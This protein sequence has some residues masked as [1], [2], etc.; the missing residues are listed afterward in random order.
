MSS[1]SPSEDPPPAAR[2]DGYADWY[3]EWASTGLTAAAEALGE[4][5]P[6]GN[7]LAV[8]VGCGTGRT[9]ELLR[10]HGYRP[11]GVDVSADQ[12][13]VARARLPVLRGEGGAL[14]LPDGSAQLVVASLI[15][16]DVEDYAGVV[17]E[18]MRVLASGGSFV[19]LG[20]HPCF[21][22]PF[23]EARSDGLLPHPGYPDAGWAAVTPW[24]G[25]TVRARVGVH[26]LPLQDL[27]TA[28]LEPRCTAEQVIEGGDYC[29]VPW[30][31]GVR[32][33]R[34]P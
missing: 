25:D 22:H 32:L 26:H 13:R 7:G 6:E 1:G 17:A 18:A 16:T 8:D 14:P 11:L 20:V 5:L 3:D 29:G 15:S 12:L 23:A 30:L 31:L 19:H 28:L 33:R 4:L 34:I 27:L 10:H 9:A 2:Y 21:R 24:T